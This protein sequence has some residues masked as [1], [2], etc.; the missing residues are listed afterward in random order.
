[1]RVET[2]KGPLGQMALGGEGYG[3]G[4]GFLERYQ[5]RAHQHKEEPPEEECAGGHRWGGDRAGPALKCIF[6][7]FFPLFWGDERK[8]QRLSLVI[9]FVFFSFSFVWRPTGSRR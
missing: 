8:G 4:V 3:S 6:S 1:M 7:C 5:G 9:S 2:P